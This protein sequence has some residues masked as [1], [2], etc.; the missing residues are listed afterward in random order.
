MK[1]KTLSLA[2][3]LAMC[4][5][6]TV[7]ALAE[8]SVWK[9]EVPGKSDA[10][11]FAGDKTFILRDCGRYDYN[12]ITHEEMFLK[13]DD[14][15]W[16][17]K[18]VCVLS[19][20]DTAVFTYKPEESTGGG[21]F[22]GG[23]WSTTSFHMIAWSDPDGDGVYDKRLIEYGDGFIDGEN[24]PYELLLEDR[25]IL[26]AGIDVHNGSVN[27]YEYG[28]EWSCSF[29]AHEDGDKA[30]LSADRVLELFGPNTLVWICD[31]IMWDE[32]DWSIL[33]E[34]GTAQPT[35]P[36][37]GSF[38]D[39][40][41]NDWFS[42]QVQ[43]AVEQEITSGTTASTFSPKKD[44][45]VAEILMFL[46]KAEG[47]PKFTAGQPYDNV[48][49]SEWYAGAALWA[50]GEG[51]VS[52]GEFQAGAPCTRAMVVEYLW[53]LAGSP[54]AGKADFDDVPSGAGYAQAVDWAV[55][56]GIT[57]GVKDNQFGPD[58]VCTRAQIVT[59]LYAA[60]AK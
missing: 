25:E 37:A 11:V 53:K 29:N 12:M 14:L 5:S 27:L 30:T 17:A 40:K 24:G 48:A 23:G 18:N 47:A 58:M 50:Y 3:A 34:G 33:V 6:L 42:K 20:G 41:E 60:L 55:E 7:P 28:T 15:Q 9:L 26:P 16:T 59:F 21:A 36:T 31:G 39:V 13:D 1:K 44:C 8:A 22:S 46:Y 52:G 19:K 51:L 57:A 56:K 35:V 38:T 54:S 45:T 2:L 43:W 4:L 49:G 32:P 10:E